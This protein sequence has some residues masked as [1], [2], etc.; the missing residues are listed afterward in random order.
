MKVLTALADH[1]DLWHV[2][3]SWSGE[4]SLHKRLLRSS[5]SPDEV[6]QTLPTLSSLCR[7]HRSKPACN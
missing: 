3:S 1:L 2:P 6:P 4:P 7:I 5:L